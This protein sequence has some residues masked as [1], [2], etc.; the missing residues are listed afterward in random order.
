MTFKA[1]VLRNQKLIFLALAIL[2]FIET[3]SYAIAGS[4]G[5]LPNYNRHVVFQTIYFLIW[6]YWSAAHAD[7]VKS[8]FDRGFFYWIIYPVFIFYSSWKNF[9]KWKGTGLF[10][11]FIIGASLPQIVYTIL[12]DNY[13]Y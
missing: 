6:M 10:F 13:Y 4:K 1:V 8:S 11:L 7:T 2:V 5:L 12:L 3:V 9:G